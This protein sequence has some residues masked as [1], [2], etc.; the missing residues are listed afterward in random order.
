M[1]IERLRSNYA[2]I[3]EKINKSAIKS[4]RKSSDVEVIVVTKKVCAEIINVL[5]E[6][7]IKHLGENRPLDGAEKKA[8]VKTG[9][10]WH[11]IG[12]VQ[13]N[14]AKAVAHNFDVIHSI[15]SMKLAGELNKHLVPIDKKMDAYLEIN[16]SGEESKL[17]IKPEQ[18][19]NILFEIRSQFKNL[20][21]IGL[22][23]MAPISED[24]ELIRYVFKNLKKLADEVL[25][26]SL[27]MGMSQDFAVAIEEGATAVR[28]GTAMFEG[29]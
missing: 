6:L 22:M 16:I 23:T 28:I 24:P 4:G 21:P 15:D 29:V 10:V 27:S 7:G 17:G 3:L 13:T 12:H 1:D 25:L 9:F 5:N 18:L 8:C 20:N 19:K 26:K 11:I 2:K 14:K